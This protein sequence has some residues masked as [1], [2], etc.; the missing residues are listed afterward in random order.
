MQSSKAAMEP[1]HVPRVANL[2]RTL[3]DIAMFTITTPHSRPVIC[4]DRLE[5]SLAESL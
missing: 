4:N 5:D 3:L 2:S 1:K